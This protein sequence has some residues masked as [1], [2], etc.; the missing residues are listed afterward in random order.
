MKKI[1]LKLTA[2]SPISHHD[3]L[4]GMDNSS[5]ARLVMRR[6]VMLNN[7]CV[8][9]PAISENSLR[10]I[11]F[12]APLADHLVSTLGIADGEL[13]KAMKATLY[14]G[15]NMAKG[16]EE[17]SAVNKSCLS[18]RELFPMFALLG[19]CASS[20]IMHESDLKITALPL[21][22]EFYDG[23]VAFGCDEQLLTKASENSAFEYTQYEEVRIC[24][25]YVR[26]DDKN[27][28]DYPM[29][30]GFE[31]FAAGSEFVIELCLD[32]RVKNIAVSALFCALNN[33]AGFVGGQNSKGY[34]RVKLDVIHNDFSVG[35]ELYENHVI[36]NRS[37]LKTAL[38]DGTLG[39]GK[40]II[41]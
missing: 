28:P 40:K 1:L 13:S 32:D 22:R 41:V 21:T 17:P 3:T 29:P 39:T 38:L 6:P 20:F 14:N 37:T 16:G 31:V 30:Y 26:D 27:E 4:T 2:L 7:N 8:R 10:H 23:L 34:G 9:V 12:R 24:Q 36:E 5:N 11:I 35:A 19:G 33:F 15:G 25:T 18:I